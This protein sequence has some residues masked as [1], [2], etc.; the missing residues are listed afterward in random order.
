MARRKKGRNISGWIIVDKPAGLTSTAVVNKLRW[1][2]SA[3]KAGHA[4]TLD[5]AATGLLAVA[6]G[7]ATK[8][9][10][11]VTDALKCYR[12]AVRLGARTNTDDAEGEVIARSDRRPSDAEIEAALPGFTGMIEQIPPRYSAVKVDGQRAYHLA[13]SGEPEKIIDRALSALDGLDILVSNA[14]GPPA[15]TFL[16]H[17]RETWIKA[18]DLTLHSAINMTRRAIPVM[19][20]AGWGR[21]IYITSVAVKQPIDNLL[22][23]NTYRA[24]LTG[25]AKS[26]SREFAKNGIT[27]NT[28][29]PGYT[30]TERLTELAGSISASTGIK[31]G[32]VFAGW[33][34]DIPAG[35]IGQPEELAALIAFLAS[36]KASFI[37]GTS[38]QVDGGYIKGLL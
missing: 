30:E 14:G 23:S 13:R 37:T 2:L 21:I 16:Q 8:I 7:E 26:I 5:P 17:D 4:G 29:L 22:I 24:G 38:I 35:R 11:V 12:F 33:T 3:R 28:V 31:T 34:A 27:V 15:G 18:A 36:E 9:I 10:P 6:F 1:A 19:K 20:E 32:E 25:F